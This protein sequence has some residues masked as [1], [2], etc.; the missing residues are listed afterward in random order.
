MLFYSQVCHTGVVPDT[1]N[2]MQRITE[3]L[4][5]NQAEALNSLW[6]SRGASG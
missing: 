6:H 1:A 2:Y 5:E 4:V 3:K